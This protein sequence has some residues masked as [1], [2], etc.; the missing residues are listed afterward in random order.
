MSF[1]DLAW[2]DIDRLVELDAQLFAE[3]AWSAPTWWA[4][5]AERP[6]RDY[7]VWTDDGEITAYGGV[8]LAADA[9]DV[10]TLAVA[11]E[12]QGR[13]LGAAVLAELERRAVEGGSDHGLLEVRADNT[14]ALA[15][16]AGHGWREL[17][18][19]RRYYQPGGIDA[20]IMGKAL[21]DRGVGDE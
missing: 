11:P 3:D 18:R 6:R 16:Y 19:R 10:M 13:G 14:A 7:V 4:E 5:L 12:A 20:I 17:H 2:A 21:Q 15:L 9:A 1:R 8:G